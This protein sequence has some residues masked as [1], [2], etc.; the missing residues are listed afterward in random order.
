MTEGEAELG[1]RVHVEPTDLDHWCRTHLHAGVGS[2]LFSEG[3]LSTVFG[4]ELTSGERIVV[5]IRPWADRLRGCVAVHR[6][7]F[8]RG[9]PCPELIVDLEPISGLAASAEAMTT[10]GASYPSTGRSPVPFARALARLVTLAPI[11]TEV[12]PLD[13]RPPWTAPAFGAPELWPPPDD[14]D[15]DLNAV[16]GPAWIDEAGRVARR[17]LAVS[18]SPVVVGHGDFYTGNLRWEGNN[19]VAVWDWDSVVAASEP[20][21]AGLAAAI[22]PAERPGS[23]ATVEESEMFLDAYQAARRRFSES[24]L[25][26]A[27]AAGLWTRSFDAK[28]QAATEGELKSLTE[29]EVVERCRRVEQR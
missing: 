28:K 11:P 12:P 5:K 22:Y 6:Q 14:R 19:L 29:A 1:R 24:E 10:G 25:A 16:D 13:P 4:L 15:V 17:K 26:E 8:E 27:W 2:V 9:F 21:L 23:E 18:T 3:Y 20:V 7:L